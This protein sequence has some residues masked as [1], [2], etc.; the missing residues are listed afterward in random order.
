MTVTIVLSLGGTYTLTVAVVYGLPSKSSRIA[1][2]TA[3]TVS[4]SIDGST[5]TVITL[6]SN[7][8]F[9]TAA[10]YLRANSTEAIVLHYKLEL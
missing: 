3:S 6:D 7:K 8:E 9:I 4:T 10:K 1:V 5:W 2:Q